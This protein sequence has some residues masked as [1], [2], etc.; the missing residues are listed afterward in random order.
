MSEVSVKKCHLVREREV[1]MPQRGMIGVASHTAVPKARL[2]G[3]LPLSDASG[4]VFLQMCI[5][6]IY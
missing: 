1:E 4:I 2:Y 6:N 5:T 3:W